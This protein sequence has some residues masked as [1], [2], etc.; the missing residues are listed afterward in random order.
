MGL[1]PAWPLEGVLRAG[2]ASLVITSIVSRVGWNGDVF[3]CV[4]NLGENEKLLKAPN[5]L[6]SS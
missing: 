3:S 5:H 1:L 2:K 4:Y 6:C